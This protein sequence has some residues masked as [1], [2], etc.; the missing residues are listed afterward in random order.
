MIT[1]KRYP[2]LRVRAELTKDEAHG[3]I[4]V[5]GTVRMEEG[6]D[7]DVSDVRIYAVRN[8]R[9]IELTKFLPENIE[10][11]LIDQVNWKAEYF[12]ELEAMT[13]AD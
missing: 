11:T 3:Y 9:T 8:G 7:F 6:M 12:D 2:D 10:S 13:C 5:H 4:A 1:Y